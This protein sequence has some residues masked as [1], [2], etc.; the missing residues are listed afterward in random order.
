MNR[1]IGAAAVL[2][3]AVFLLAYFVLFPAQE[4]PGAQIAT[5]AP[6]TQAPETQ[7]PEAQAEAVEP[8]NEAA[9]A[10]AATAE[11]ADEAFEAAVESV[12]AGAS[13]VSELAEFAAGTAQTEVSKPE[14]AT[15]VATLVATQMEVADEPPAVTQTVRATLSGAEPVPAEEIQIAV[16]PSTLDAAT[17]EAAPEPRPPRFDVVRIEPNGE[18]VVAGTSEPHSIVFVL[19]GDRVWGRETAQA[20]GAWVIIPDWPLTPG[21]HMLGL[22]AELEDGRVLLSDTVVVVSVPAPEVRVAGTGPAATAASEAAVEVSG[23][24][25]LPLAVAMTRETSPGASRIL[26]QPASRGLRDREL[27]LQAVDY[28]ATGLVVISGYAEPGARLIVYLDDEPLGYAVADA[29]GFWKVVPARPVE[30]GL[31]RL[32]VDRVD[33]AGRVL[34]RVATSFSRAELAG[35][36]P[37]D[38]FVIVQPGN[39]LWRIARRTYGQG[40]RYAVIYQA[41]RGQIGDPDLIHP[42]QIFVVPAAN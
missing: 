37:E 39:S 9:E 10:G 22:R 1:L 42:G 32:R 21:D 27:V 16:L 6:E 28:D 36:F 5:Q 14:L 3:G 41:N 17:P 35:G 18:A 8:T 7:A 30:V 15:P 19:D 23:A 13:A 38:R 24:A 12:K 29:E 40:I 4:K 25:E 31:H 26:Q 34:A 2:A 11:S 20:S 33:E